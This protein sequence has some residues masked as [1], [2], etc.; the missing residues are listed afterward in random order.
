MLCFICWF[1]F[2]CLVLAVYYGVLFRLKPDSAISL[3]AIAWRSSMCFARPSQLYNTC[4]VCCLKPNRVQCPPKLK[5]GFSPRALFTAA[6]W[7]AW[8][9]LSMAR[10]QHPGEGGI[11]PSYEGRLPVPLPWAR[12]LCACRGT[13]IEAGYRETFMSPPEHCRCRI[14]KLMEMAHAAVFGEGRKSADGQI[15]PSARPNFVSEES[16]EECE[17]RHS[18]LSSLP[19]SLASPGLEECLGRLLLEGEVLEPL[20]HR[21]VHL[22]GGTRK[23]SRRALTVVDCFL[24]LCVYPD[25]L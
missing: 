18:T 22:L 7:R 23:L 2:V 6:A 11:R 3:L 19:P 14:A 20:H 13:P 10:G 9:F 16:T 25:V 17:H 24:I 8:R 4:G 1:L 21:L 5:Q 12:N 15:L